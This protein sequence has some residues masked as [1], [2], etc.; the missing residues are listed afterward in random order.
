MS[1]GTKLRTK[2]ILFASPNLSAGGAQRQTINIANGLHRRGYE[3]SVFLFYDEGELKNS[4]DK[5][6]K[7]FSPLFVPVLKKSKILW[8]GYGI[9]HFFKTALFEKPD[10]L[11][12]RHWPK[13]PMAII[14]RMLRFKTI[15]G[16]GN[17]LKQ[18]FSMEKI[19]LRFY[20]RKFGVRLSNKVVANSQSLAL[21]TKEVFKLRSEVK[22]IYNGI[23]IQNVIERSKKE[24]N[25]KWFGTE[26]PLIIAVGSFKPQK[27]FSYLLQ[28]LEIVNR[29]KTVRLIILGN[30]GKKKELQNFSEKLLIKDKIDFLGAVANPFPYIA[31]AD[32]FVSSSLYE[33]FSNV[34]L[35]AL[36]LGKPII[37]TNH[38]HGADEIIEDH[39][40]GILVPVKNPRKMADAIIKI[41]EDHELK[42]SLEKEAKKRSENFSIDKMISRYE[43]LFTEI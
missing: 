30:G 21:E 32:I 23:D 41:L 13:I 12:S 9:I 42:E 17:N 10:I 35:E 26:I 34:I 18:T 5:S 25:H 31:K 24:N 1:K 20:L 11:Y 22:T 2:K 8:V 19:P 37:S 39:K 15:S 27:G 3:V 28:A 16:E 40:N 7:I 43:K 33:G 14:G 6:I 29:T 38:E 36:A 4:L